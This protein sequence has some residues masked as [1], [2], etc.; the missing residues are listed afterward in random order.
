MP[1]AGTGLAHVG[2]WNRCAGLTLRAKQGLA[3]KTLLDAVA[4]AYQEISDYGE[5]LVNEILPG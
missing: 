2:D 5:D 3:T 1:G 4:S